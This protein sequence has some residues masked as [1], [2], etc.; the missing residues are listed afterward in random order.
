MTKTAK[1]RLTN[2]VKRQIQAAAL[3]ALHE[4]GHF[5][6]EERHVGIEADRCLCGGITW[7]GNLLCPD[8][9]RKAAAKK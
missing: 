6:A 2:K 1:P 9:V 4:R 7:G 8:C 5:T 3:R